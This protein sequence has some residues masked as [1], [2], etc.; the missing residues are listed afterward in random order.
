M[1]NTLLQSHDTLTALVRKQ[2]IDTWQ[3]LL[4][5][6]KRLPYGRN[7]NRTNLA[8]VL[9]QQ[10]GSCSSKHALLKKV[11]DLNGI[12]NVALILGLYKMNQQNTPSIGDVL[13]TYNLNY[14]PEAHCYLKIRG[15]RID[16]T[17]AASDFKKL[18][19]DIVQELEIIPDQVATFKVEYHRA[20]LKHWIAENAL[21]QNFE[22][23]WN[24]RERCIA[25]LTLHANA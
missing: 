23:I 5:F 19:K 3:A 16:V 11:A 17:T 4:A 8:L 13:N 21:P 6:V 24:I 14:I 18:E 7:A 25:N 9:T 10:K 12:P 2:G 1:I 20:F 22:E 15:K